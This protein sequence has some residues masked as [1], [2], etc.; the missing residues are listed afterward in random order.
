MILVKPLE[1]PKANRMMIINESFI[2]MAS[3]HL[4]FFT[5]YLTDPD[6]QYNIGWSLI[7]VTL[8]NMVINL[9]VILRETIPSS[10]RSFIRTLKR[11]KVVL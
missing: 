2:L 7:A 6:L 1:D 8:L 3:Y 9:A 5:D 4:F 10:I 11:A